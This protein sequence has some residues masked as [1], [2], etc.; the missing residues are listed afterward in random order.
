[1]FT[2]CSRSFLVAIVLHFKPWDKVNK[3]ELNHLSAFYLKWVRLPDGHRLFTA[4]CRLLGYAEF[5]SNH[6]REDELHFKAQYY[7]IP[8]SNKMAFVKCKS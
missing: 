8:E 3:T 5:G 7:L 1:M 2:A 6:Y 4:V